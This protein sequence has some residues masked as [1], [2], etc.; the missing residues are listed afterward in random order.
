MRLK[1]SKTKRDLLLFVCLKQTEYFTL[2][3]VVSNE[4]L[5]PKKKSKERSVISGNFLLL[6]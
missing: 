5:V 2:K 4:P 3:Y 6:H 1:V